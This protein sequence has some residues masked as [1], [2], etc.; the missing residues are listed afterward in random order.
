MCGRYQVSIEE[1]SKGKKIK[2][3]AEQLNLSYSQGEIFPTNKVL[4]Y[5]SNSSIIDLASMKWGINNNSLQINARY[6]SLDDKPLYSRM[7]NNRCA[8]I[9]TG[10]YEWDKEKRKYFVHTNDKY[11][12]LACIF[13]DNNELLIITKEAD[14]SFSKVHN[15]IPIIMNEEEMNDYLSSKK[16][17]ITEKAIIIDDINEQTSLF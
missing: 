10:F 1:D 6:E 8:V 2:Q 15:R 5:V 13:N 3:R 9:A 16:P 7:K 14:D 4:C 17:I 12:Y 11:I